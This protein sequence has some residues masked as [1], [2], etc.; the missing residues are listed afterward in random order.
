Y[1]YDYF[2]DNCATKMPDILAH[3]FGDT[4]EFDGSHIRTDYSIRELTD[5]YLRLQPWG[6][7][8]I[9]IC[10]GLPIDKQAT[11]YEYMF[12]PDYVEAGMANATILK[13][14][15]REPLVKSRTVIYESRFEKEQTP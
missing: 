4:I 9:D 14:G 3:V 7:L 11:P 6:D 10:L 2:Y 1:R 13:N 12:L 5:L 8:G 15:I